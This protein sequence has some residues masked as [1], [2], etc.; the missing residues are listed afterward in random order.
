MAG[1]IEHLRFM[2]AGADARSALTPASRGASV[3]HYI[4]AYTPLDSI[5]YGTPN[6]TQ[7]LGAFHGA[8]VPLVLNTPSGIA[9]NSTR[10]GAAEQLLALQMGCYWVPHPSPPLSAACI[11]PAPSTTLL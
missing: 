8:E 11:F 7:Y 9:D 6:L 5:N 10:H 2:E 1:R 4:F 3:Y